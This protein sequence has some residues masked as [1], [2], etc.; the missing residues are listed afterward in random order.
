MPSISMLRRLLTGRIALSATHVSAKY[1]LHVQVCRLL[2]QLRTAPSI[3]AINVHVLGWVRQGLTSHSTHFRS[4]W[5]RWGTAASAR[6]VA[7]VRG[8]SVCGVE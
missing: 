4:F 8:H 7:A 1:M 6:I 3:F 5:R 2:L